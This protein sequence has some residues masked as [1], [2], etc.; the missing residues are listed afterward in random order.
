MCINNNKTAPVGGI[1]DGKEFDMEKF[2]TKKEFEEFARRD[3]PDV[4]RHIP[5]HIAEEALKEYSEIEELFN[6]NQGKTFEGLYSVFRSKYGG[7]VFH[8]DCELF[9]IMPN[10]VSATIAKCNGKPVLLSHF[11]IDVGEGTR[12]RWE[13]N[14]TVE[15]LQDIIKGA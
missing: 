3:S 4:K 6:E 15:E 10:R 1:S 12:C 11:D 7:N 8:F 13:C 2:K 5:K 9:D 14:Y